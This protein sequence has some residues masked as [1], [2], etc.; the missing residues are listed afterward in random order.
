M[1]KFAIV[2]NNTV[3]NVV[4]SDS[5]FGNAKGW[6]PVPDGMSVK[7]GDQYINGEFISTPYVEAVPEIVTMRQGRLALLDAGLLSVVNSTV[8]TQPLDV[9]IAWEYS[10]ELERNNP[11]IAGLKNVLGLTDND[12]DALFIAASKK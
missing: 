10:S 4:E 8:L 9:Q 3:M 2:I 6:I 11:V 5:G 12:L 7:K 1:A